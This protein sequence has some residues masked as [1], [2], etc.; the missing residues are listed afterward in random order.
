MP[1]YTNTFKGTTGAD[2]VTTSFDDTLVLLGDDNDTLSVARFTNSKAILHTGDDQFNANYAENVE[3]WGGSGDDS[4]TIV[5]GQNVK[6]YGGSGND[7]LKATGLVQNSFF[8]GETGNDVIVVKG[9]NNTALGGE[10]NDRIR[11]GGFNNIAD[12]GGGNDTLRILSGADNLIRGGAGN[13]TLYN[14]SASDGNQL[15]GD[16]GNDTIYDYNDNAVGANELRGGD[17]NDTIFAYGGDDFIVTGGGN[18]TAEGGAGNDTFHFNK[19]DSLAGHDVIVDLEGAN[20]FE[21]VLTESELNNITFNF[22]G[23]G[24]SLSISQGATTST[25]VGV[26]NAQADNID[27]ISFVIDGVGTATVLN[28]IT[29]NLLAYNVGGELEYNAGTNEVDVIVGGNV[30]YNIA[31]V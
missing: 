24:S 17:G 14:L 8:A 2:N 15:F 13:D 9:V 5:A 27:S 11:I 7:L 10:G 1:T 26:S 29:Q 20:K 23:V 19:Y 28:N 16:T 22:S 18:D 12:G 4:L 21:F 6:F 30:I 3:V 31:V 25:T